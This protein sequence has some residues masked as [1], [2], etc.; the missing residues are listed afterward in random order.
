MI[1][2]LFLICCGVVVGVIGFYVA[3]IYIMTD[4]FKNIFGK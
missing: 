4:G 2:D 3:F 1:W